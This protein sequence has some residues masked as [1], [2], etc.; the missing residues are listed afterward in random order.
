[1]YPRNLQTAL[2]DT[3]G[4]SKCMK[5]ES[6][7]GHED[8]VGFVTTYTNQCHPAYN[9]R[10]VALSLSDISP[11]EVVNLWVMAKSVF[12]KK[13]VVRRITRAEVLAIWD[14]AGKIWY[15]EMSGETIK[16]ALTH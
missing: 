8:I 13:P 10:G 16:R 1:M 4:P 15:N 6:R 2:D 9:A 11:D 7:E 12:S 3:V 5:F 14:Y